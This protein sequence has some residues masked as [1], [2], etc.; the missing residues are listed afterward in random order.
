MGKDA[1]FLRVA[2]IVAVDRAFAPYAESSD[3]QSQRML[4]VSA[5]SAKQNSIASRTNCCRETPRFTAAIPNLSNSA[6][7]SASEN[8]LVLSTCARGDIGSDADQSRAEFV[9]VPMSGRIAE[10]AT[11]PRGSWLGACHGLASPLRA[12]R[13]DVIAANLCRFT[14]GFPIFVMDRG[15]DGSA[16]E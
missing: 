2:R 6:G 11:S 5:V 16:P 14:G 7:E 12:S 10:L 4:S 9:P 13:L 1:L 8:R 3:K 15:R